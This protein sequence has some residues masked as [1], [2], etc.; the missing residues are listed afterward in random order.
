MLGVGSFGQHDVILDPV[1]TAEVR[2]VK[3][4]NGLN[5]WICCPSMVACFV[6]LL[7]PLIPLY[8]L[9]SL[10]ASLPPSLLPSLPSSLSDILLPLP[11]KANRVDCLIGCR[12]RSDLLLSWGANPSSTVC[13]NGRILRRCHRGGWLCLCVDGVVRTSRKVCTQQKYGPLLSPGMAPTENNQLFKVT[14]RLVSY[15]HPY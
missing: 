11:V 7:R 10:L 3:K 12:N 8:L 1:Y 13:G 5:T 4:R 15:H 2:S 14:M 9:V 6:V